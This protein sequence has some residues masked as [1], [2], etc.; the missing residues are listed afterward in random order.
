[1]ETDSKQRC[2]CYVEVKNLINILVGI[3]T[4]ILNNCID[5]GFLILLMFRSLEVSKRDKK[6]LLAFFFG[7]I[8]VLTGII[9]AFRD[10]LVLGEILYEL[11]VFPAISLI[12]WLV[13]K[14]QFYKYELCY[15]LNRIGI[16]VASYLLQGVMILV[17]KSD[18]VYFNVA[19][20]E[21]IPAWFIVNVIYA[22]ISYGLYRLCLIIIRG[23]KKTSKVQNGIAIAYVF[24]TFITEVVIYYVIVL[25]VAK[26]MTA[27]VVLFAL[28]MFASI[29][30]IVFALYQNRQI[31]REN[32]L[33]KRHR[34]EEMQYYK[35]LEKNQLVIRKMRHDMINYFQTIQH[36]SKESSQAK[37]MLAELEERLVNQDIGD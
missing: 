37:E 12:P 24:A 19:M 5:N 15:A 33:L 21:K 9:S 2:Y 29:E 34:E 26:S 20:P 7:V 27:Y 11:T 3:I 31:E 30:V 17:T 8:P 16:G 18:E 35:K 25:G 28:V 23:Y 6:I 22:L 10:N 36:F 4:T 14:R 1:M 13:A 32:E